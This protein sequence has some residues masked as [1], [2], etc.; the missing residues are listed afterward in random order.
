MLVAIA[1]WKCPGVVQASNPTP[2]AAVDDDSVIDRMVR[3]LQEATQG[4][5]AGYKLQPVQF[6]KVSVAGNH[7]QTCLMLPWTSYSQC[8]QSCMCLT[9][10][11]FI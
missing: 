2:S 1:K 9:C 10:S 3:Q 8:C 4:L 5:P 6:E 7:R 11:G